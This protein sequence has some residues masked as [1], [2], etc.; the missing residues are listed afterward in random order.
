[1]SLDTD[2]LLI[3]PL[4]IGIAV[5]DTIHFMTHYR[6]ALIKTGN[7]AQALTS[8]VR[9]VGQAVM[10]TSMVLGLG[11][12]L[13]SFSQYLGMAK[14]GFFGAFAIFIALLCDLFFLPALIMIFKPKFGLKNLDSSFR[15]QGETA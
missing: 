3:A 9:D 8:T 4:V 10:F 15:F 12:G 6:V 1:M 2:T 5:D 7:M 11:F 14:V 13:M